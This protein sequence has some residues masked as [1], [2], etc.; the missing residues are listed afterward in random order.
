MIVVIHS[1][2]AGLVLLNVYVVYLIIFLQCVEAFY[3]NTLE[4]TMVA[5]FL[6]SKVD[7]VIAMFS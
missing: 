4:V 7:F 5:S 1:E 3:C 2:P 6:P